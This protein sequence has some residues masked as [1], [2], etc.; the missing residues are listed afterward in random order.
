MVWLQEPPGTLAASRA[1]AREAVSLPNQEAAAREAISLPNSPRKGR[2]KIRLEQRR[3]SLPPTDA[4][5]QVV[6][7]STPRKSDL[8]ASPRGKKAWAKRVSLIE[9]GLR[10][11]TVNELSGVSLRSHFVQV[12]DVFHELASH[13]KEFAEAEMPED[14]DAGGAHERGVRETLRAQL[15]FREQLVAELTG[16]PP[17]DSLA[18]PAPA[19]PAPP[20]PEPKPEPQGPPMPTPPT[21]P[22]PD[23]DDE[24][25]PPPLPGGSGVWSKLLQPRDAS[26]TGGAGWAELLE[27]HPGAAPPSPGSGAGKQLWANAQRLERAANKKVG[28]AELLALRKSGEERASH[29]F[30]LAVG[31]ERAGRDEPTVAPEEVLALLLSRG[32]ARADA[33]QLLAAIEGNEAAKHAPH[34]GGAKGGAERAL[35][36]AGSQARAGPQR[37]AA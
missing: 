3:N 10:M 26:P 20:A 24:A 27:G 2:S 11:K 19:P 33:E 1:A 5:G 8:S 6:P 18:P 25:A 32:M 22:E 14:A 31:E 28:I 15:K 17:D 21:S 4:D 37:T 16:V 7:P 36:A 13:S 35:P 34:E 29:L 30:E 9:P 23:N 12:A